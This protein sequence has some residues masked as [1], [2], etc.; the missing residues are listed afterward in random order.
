MTLLHRKLV[1]DIRAAFWQFAAIRLVAAVGIALFHGFLVAYLNQKVS[2]AISYDR[3]RFADMT[4]AMRSAPRFLTY[5]LARLPG[6]RA[7]EGRIVKDVEVEQEAGRR[8]RV[9]GRLITIP[10]D[11]LPAVN[12]FVVLEGHAILS[13]TRREVLLEA[14]FAR[15]NHYRPGDRLYPRFGGHRVAFVV[16][17]I[18]TSPEYIY[19]VASRQSSLPLPETFGVMFAAQGQ[20]ESQLGMVGAMNEVDLLTEPGQAAAVGALVARRLHAYGPEAPMGRDE[21]PSNKLLQTSLEGNKPF[22]VVMPMLFLAAAALAVAL[23]LARWGQ[24]QR[25]QVGFL[26]ASGFPPG[27]ILVHYLEV[28]AVIGAGGGV[29][30]VVLGH[31]LGL[32]LSSVYEQFLHMPYFQRD[33][34]PEVA[35]VAFCLS[36]LA[37][38][39]GALGPAQQ[40]ARIAPAEAMR[41]ETPMRGGHFATG[42]LPLA[43]ALPLR[44]LLRRPLRSLGTA[45]GVAVS[46]ILMIIAGTLSDSLDYTLNL[47]L[48][49]IQRYDLSVTFVPER[50]Q[51]ILFDISQWP[52]VRRVEPTLEI[53]VRITHDGHE[54]E[55]VAMGVIP[56]A[57]LQ[58]LPGPQGRPLTPPHGAALMNATLAEDLGSEP[59]DLLSLKYTQN[60]EERHA[61]T[62]IHAGA[63]IQQPIGYPLY[64]RLEEL[65][66]RFA[67]PLKMP[68]DAISGALLEV[69]PRYMESVR[70]RLNRTEGVGLVQARRE[71]AREIETLTAF[72]R[73]FISLLYLLG[74]VMALAVTYTATD[75]VLWERTRE[76]ATLR[77]LGFSMGRLTFLVTLENLF[78]GLFGALAGVYPGIA[79]AGYLM[80]AKS[81]ESFG[82]SPA[83]FPRTYLLTVSG[84]LLVVCLAQVPGLL[85]IRRLDLAET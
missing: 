47:F 17:G 53:P 70:N 28:G 11:R 21:Q 36:L 44:N 10:A 26:R 75:S 35:A 71:L 54:K 59:G 63:L 4:V 20:V 48:H 37:C 77:T 83:T 72:S 12:R 32:W 23:V 25:A 38:V 41:G 74:L 81:S 65:Q 7:V 34:H 78:V 1:R 2:Y 18:V 6:V 49:Q 43:L 5:S 84:A 42:R 30:G 14:S 15:A 24:A 40:A 50:S 33:A 29:L 19:P 64:M 66:A 73:A 52:G 68:P 79:A 16:A 27:A 76:L 62:R 57:R 82:L 45:S 56:N 60:T 80:S 67:A 13:G 58:Q 85:R 3:L 46:V 61:S 55:T 8:P 22:L 39:L 9:I 51:A 69:D 31:L